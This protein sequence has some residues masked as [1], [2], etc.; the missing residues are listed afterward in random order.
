MFLIPYLLILIII[1]LAA[2]IYAMFGSINTDKV[3]KPKPTKQK[4]ETYNG[5]YVDR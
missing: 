3:N 5:F 2:I 1:E 4:R